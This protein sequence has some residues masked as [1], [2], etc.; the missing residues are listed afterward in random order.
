[1]NVVDEQPQICGLAKKGNNNGS[2]LA[3]ASPCALLG[4]T[5]R[6]TSLI[7]NLLQ[8]VVPDCFNCIEV[9]LSRVIFQNVVRESITTIDP[10]ALR[11]S[12]ATFSSITNRG[13]T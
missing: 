12:R 7:P 13:P 11:R 4:Y 9:G 2:T 5:K 1:M 10:A 3:Q 8:P 6:S